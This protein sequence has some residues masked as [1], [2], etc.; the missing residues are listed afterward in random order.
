MLF[1]SK[2]GDGR[3]DADRVVVRLTSSGQLDST[4]A[5]GGIHTLNLSNN[6]DN[7]RH[8]FVQGDGKIVTAGYTPQPTGVGSQTANRIVL[9]R[10]LDNG[11]PDSSFG[12]SGVVNSALFVPQDPTAEWGMAEAYTAVPQGSKYV[13]TGYGRA[14][15][16]GKVDVVSARY[17]ADGTLDTTWGDNGV[18]VFDLVGEDDRGRNMVALPDNRMLIV[19]SGVPTAGNLQAMALMLTADGEVDTSFNTTGYKLYDFGRPDEAF[20]GAALNPSGDTVAA[21]GYR[22]GGSGANDDGVLL[23][24]PISGGGTEVAKEIPIS[25]TNHDR[26]WSVAY[27]PGG[28]FYV[29]GFVTESGDSSMVVARYNS[30]GSID[31]T[32]GTN[33][34]AKHNVVAK[35]TDEAARAIVVQSDGKVVLVGNVEVP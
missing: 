19:G 10:L 22:A 2:K 34:V 25:N 26:L 13:T 28:K 12:T 9:L 21:V 1:G 5:T 23:L 4:F 3:S 6:P 20:F 17:N 14:A 35:G 33:G 8:G 27:E 30:D 29:A 24:L 11:L 31:T 7:A 15:P 16:S 18:S 32:F